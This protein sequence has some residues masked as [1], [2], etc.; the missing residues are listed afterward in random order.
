[1]D[2]R[3]KRG[4]LLLADL[5]GF[6]AFLTA[7]EL[8][9]AHDILRELIE[10]IVRR[11]SAVFQLAEVEGDAVYVY[12]VEPA[13]PSGKALLDLV[14]STYLAFR[15]RADTIDRRSTCRCSACRSVALLD[16]KFIVHYGEFVL[17]DVAGG[18]K[19]LGSD[20]N[21][22]HR[23]LKNSVGEATGWRAY[24]LFS[25]PAVLRAGLEVQGWHVQPEE[26]ASLGSVQ[27][28]SLDLLARLP[29]MRRSRRGAVPPEEA[30]LRFVFQV[31]LPPA[32]TW[33]WLND[34]SMRS[35]WEG[36][37][38]RPEGRGD[39]L[40]GV[41]AVTHCLHGG[42]VRSLQ[43]ILEWRPAE[44]FTYES[45]GPKGTTPESI[46]T[47]VLTPTDSGTSVDL[48]VRVEIQPRWLG[49][50]LYRLMA[51]GEYRR[52]I[53]RLQKLTAETTKSPLAA[54]T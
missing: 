23:L 17:Q 53:D 51:V 3:T 18:R 11:L 36:L 16:L 39:D 6:T 26:F 45:R 2:T 46:T 32:A 35:L 27:T 9:H 22:A 33:A 4:Y 15:D 19:P 14:E 48:R 43:T 31:D 30:D 52:S 50:R 54:P 24:A 13:L 7:S 28:Y 47:V 25:E 38:V 41:G 40:G 34:V 8:E 10:L 5:S 21:L 44:T 29:D 20:V 12:A 1:M 49:I 42:K 37:P